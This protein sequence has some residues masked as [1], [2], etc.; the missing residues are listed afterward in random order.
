MS[1][2]RRLAA[3][4]IDFPETQTINYKAMK[5]LS[6]DDSTFSDKVIYH[7]YSKKTKEGILVLKN[8]ILKINSTAFVNN[9]F[10]LSIDIPTSVTEISSGAFEG[11]INLHTVN[12]KNTI[13]TINDNTF[14][15]CT[16]LK[17]INIDNVLDSIGNSVFEN[18]KS[19]TNIVFSESVTSIGNSC[20]KNCTKL[21]NVIL[22]KNI[23]ELPEYCFYDCE[24][25]EFIDIPEGV[26]TLNE[27]A[28]NKVGGVSANI[29]LTLNKIIIDNIYFSGYKEIESWYFNDLYI[30]DIDSYFNISWAYINNSVGDVGIGKCKNLYVNNELLT[31]Y[32]FS[33]TVSEIKNHLF[34]GCQCIEEITFP[35]NSFIINEGAFSSCKNLSTLNNFDKCNTA[36]LGAFSYCNLNAIDLSN[37]TEI[38][39]AFIAGNKNITTITIPDTINEIP[40]Y[41]FYKCT[42]LQSITL[43]NNITT[44]GS[45]A[46]AEC[47]NLQEIYIPETVT[48][49]D[50]F[51]F[52]ECKSLNNINIE[53]VI[54]LNGRIFENCTNIQ[55]IILNDSITSLP[56]RIFYGCKNLR[57]INTENI[58][59]IGKEAFDYCESL[60]TL[61]ISKDCN[62]SYSIINHREIAPFIGC[63]N[64][65]II[66]DEENLNY[67]IVDDFF[68]T[69]DGS[70]IICCAK[71]MEECVIPDAIT[72]IMIGA[73]QNR[74]FTSIKFGDNVETIPY[75]L[76]KNCENLTD[77][78]FNN[79]YTIH[80][81]AFEGCISLE[82]ITFTKEVVFGE[83][84]SNNVKNTFK[85]CVNLK[86]VNFSNEQT[87]LY[88]DVFANCVS[89]TDLYIPEG[90]TSINGSIKNSNIKNIHAT[91]LDAWLSIDKDAYYTAVKTDGF[92]NPL[93]YAENLYIDGE[94]VTD[95][96][97]NR[98]A[99]LP[100]LGYNKLNSITIKNNYYVTGL[101]FTNNPN[102]II[103]NPSKGVGMIFDEDNL[104]WYGYNVSWGSTEGGLSSGN[105]VIGNTVDFRTGLGYGYRYVSSY[106]FLNNNTVE[107]VYLKRAKIEHYAFY[108]CTKI[109][110]FFIEEGVPLEGSSSVNYLRLDTDCFGEIKSDYKIAI[111]DD[112]YDYWYDILK[113]INIPNIEDRVIT[114]T[115][116]DYFQELKTNQPGY[117]IP[118]YVK[119]LEPTSVKF[120]INPIE[121][122][123]DKYTWNTLAVGESTPTIDVGE[124]I[125]FRAKDLT[126]TSAN[127]IGTFSISGKCE[128]GGNAMSMIWGDEFEIHNTMRVNYNLKR[129][130]Y[131]QSGNPDTSIVNAEKMVIGCKEVSLQ[132]CFA[133]FVRCNA[134]IKGCV[135]PATTIGERAYTSMYQEC[136][137]L[138]IGSDLPAEDLTGA[139]LC[140][141]A[142]YAY[143]PKMRY[144]KAMIVTPEPNNAGT[145]GA[146]TGNW[147]LGVATTGTFVKNIKATWEVNGTSGIPSGWEVK[148]AEE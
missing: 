146:Q 31:T 107:Y 123:L 70:Q 126:A 46:F 99:I 82:E 92:Y 102:I 66:L 54:T 42:N 51:A 53:N 108:G 80:N 91:S 77:I 34:I 144:L 13:S 47:T 106:S 109:K 50:G 10:L 124:K 90:V 76:C 74:N 86:Y 69:K 11:C 52:A 139:T 44:I 110:A 60:E 33:D 84:P 83:F 21:N 143:C 94:L 56:F 63:N 140:Y 41:L 9:R 116:W 5:K 72:S 118:L 4:L 3:Q 15:N 119:A 127:G 131:A 37:L 73:F 88:L 129:L 16:S 85:D 79:I 96:V 135:L 132:G 28:F 14:K 113:S 93:V 61:N 58:I 117:D 40:D 55:A 98:N 48:L 45:Y 43:S 22:P 18:C 148:L 111:K 23:I 137:N 120:S 125:Y 12:I 30:K 145:I 17:S 2:F 65:N 142:I 38:P 104:L 147:L 67:S 68:C 59:T 25:L 87:T 1:N 29:P 64:L 20:F 100:F 133:M 103:E 7:N 122:S 105:T 19:L 130:F 24:L 141:N 57:T 6:I 8:N 134:L 32:T 95:V 121:Y 27:Y 101:S 128:L 35:N 39:R 81:S 49:I 36:H 115:E 78:D 138:E 62:I 71:P 97:M 112:L 114:R 26:T 75:N 89:F 136:A